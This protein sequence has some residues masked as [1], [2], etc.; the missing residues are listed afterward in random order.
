M[1]KRHIKRITFKTFISNLFGRKPNWTAV[2]LAILILGVMYCYFG[3]DLMEYSQAV[4]DRTELARQA[5]QS[6]LFETGMDMEAIEAKMQEINQ[7]IQN[8]SQGTDLG[9]LFAS[10]DLT[11]EGRK[12]NMV[13]RALAL[14]ILIFFSGYVLMNFIRTFWRAANNR[15]NEKTGRFQKSAS[16]SKSA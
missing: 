8:L 10:N 12:A 6:I 11:V 7:R 3:G 15:K 5:E 14:V 1:K 2:I 4:S 16:D 9:E 13:Y